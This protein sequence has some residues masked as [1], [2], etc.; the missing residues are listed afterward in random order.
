ANRIE[1]EQ[2]RAGGTVHAC[3]GN[4]TN[5]ALRLLRRFT[6]MALAER[7]SASRLIMSR[8]LL[9]LVI[10]ATLLGGTP[11]PSVAQEMTQPASQPVPIVS[12]QS[13]GAGASGGTTSGGASVETPPPTAAAPA[14][15]LPAGPPAGQA[16]AFYS[17]PA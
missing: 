13:G 14:E 2:G 16:A 12:G 15:P 11:A 4:F 1:R 8:T 17:N 6:S 9:S 10:T 5:A 3:T 7:T